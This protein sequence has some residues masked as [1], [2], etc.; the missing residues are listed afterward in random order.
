MLERV[1]NLRERTGVFKGCKGKLVPLFSH[2]ERMSD[3]E[4]LT[5]ISLLLNNLYLRLQGRDNLVHNLFN[6]IKSLDNE[7]SGVETSALKR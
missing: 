1:L 2:P 3:F 5:D 4:Y 7:T 6:H